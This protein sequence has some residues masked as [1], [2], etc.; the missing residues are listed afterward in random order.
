MAPRSTMSSLRKGKGLF[1]TLAAS[2]L[3][4]AEKI[5]AVVLKI[6]A[7]EGEGDPAV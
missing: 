7:P 2:T 4:F 5:E 3:G 1:A 6:Q